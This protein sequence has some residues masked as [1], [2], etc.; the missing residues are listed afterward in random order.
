MRR[1]RQNLAKHREDLGGES[2]FCSQRGAHWLRVGP[3]ASSSG[4]YRSHKSQHA[5]P[6]SPWASAASNPSAGRECTASEYPCRALCGSGCVATL[7]SS[8]AAVPGGPQGHQQVGDR[9]EGLCGF[10]TW[11]MVLL[12]PT[13]GIWGLSCPP[14]SRRGPQL[15]WEGPHGRCLPGLL[16]L[17]MN[18]A[19]LCAQM[20]F[21]DKRKIKK[22]IQDMGDTSWIS[23]SEEDPCFL[24]TPDGVICQPQ[25]CP[26]KVKICW[27]PGVARVTLTQL[28]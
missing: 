28:S 18:T 24:A 10:G 12:H 3:G 9:A 22:L 11:V 4:T 15:P 1:A 23:D 5:A 25:I 16:L 8:A 6:A 17:G 14:G 26:P 7:V 13:C 2:P 19:Q 20:H 27:L 21:A